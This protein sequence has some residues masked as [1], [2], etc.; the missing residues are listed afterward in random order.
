MSSTNGIPSTSPTTTQSLPEQK[1][2]QQSNKNPICRLCSSSNAWKSE[3]D[4]I[5]LVIYPDCGNRYQSI[6]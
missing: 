3:E 1:T 5:E 4:G 2:N 6:Q